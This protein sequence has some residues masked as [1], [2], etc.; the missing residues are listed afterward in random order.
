MKIKLNQKKIKLNRKWPF[1]IYLF[2]PKIPK[3][4]F[5]LTQP[6]SGSTVIA[7]YITNNESI[8]SLTHNAEGHRLVNGL[9]STY[10]NRWNSNYPDSYLKY[11][12]IKSTY[13]KSFYK[14]NK[15]KNI[16]FI[17]EKSP[18]N[19]VRYKKLAKLFDKNIILINFRNPY[20]NILSQ[21]K[22]FKKNNSITSD[23]EILDKLI[24]TY[25]FRQEFLFKAL[26]EGVQFINY[27][28]FCENPNLIYKKLK[29]KHETNQKDYFK[30]KVKDYS[31]SKIFNMNQQFLEDEY[32]WHREVIKKEIIEYKSR[33]FDIGYEL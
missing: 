31:E 19:I 17:F 1:S 8:G 24:R 26:D 2:Y 29:I 9:Y 28:K 27:E 12:S 20:A 6:N 13:K 33:F 18:T 30:T 3:F 7:K 14:N 21:L 10:Q 32:S 4:I 25:I 16:E 22:R 5:L 15:R 11:L 23:K